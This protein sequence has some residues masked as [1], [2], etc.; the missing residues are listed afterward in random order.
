MNAL[1]ARRVDC[2][3]KAPKGLSPRIQ[4]LR[5]YYF[6]GSKRAWNNGFTAWS[7]GTP[8]DLQYQE[9]IKTS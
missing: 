3:L 8:W 1:T 5:D 2:Q 9:L 4:W 7:T 6:Q